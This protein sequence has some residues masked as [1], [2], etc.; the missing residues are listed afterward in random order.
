MEMFLILTVR[1][2]CRTV[3]ICQNSA[4]VKQIDTISNHNIMI[5]VQGINLT[6]C[7]N[8]HEENDKAVWMIWQRQ[9]MPSKY[10]IRSLMFHS[11]LGSSMVAKWQQTTRGSGVRRCW[12][13]GFVITH[14]FQLSPLLP[15]W[16]EDWGVP[17]RICEDRGCLACTGIYLSWN[18]PLLCETIEIWSFFCW[19]SEG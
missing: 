15:Q 6:T 11:L 2:S 16:S 14:L 8:R 19:G 13:E 4:S 5:K 10:T 3:Y 9:L 18:N 7:K 12:R 17:A 1:G